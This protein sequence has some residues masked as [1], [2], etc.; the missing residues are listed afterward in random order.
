MTTPK[1]VRL[2]LPHDDAEE[3]HDHLA[4]AAPELLITHA[5]A[6]RLR[7]AVVECEQCGDPVVMIRDHLRFCSAVCRL[8]AWREE[9]GA[10][11]TNGPGPESYE[12]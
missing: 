4:G 1:P 5:L 10:A 3:A 9:H 11:V 7:R 6:K 8:K 2:T 12:G